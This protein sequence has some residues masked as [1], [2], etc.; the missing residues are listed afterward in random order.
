[1]A[2]N[3]DLSDGKILTISDIS[4]VQERLDNVYT[5]MELTRSALLNEL[6]KDSALEALKVIKFGKIATDPLYNGVHINYI[7]MLNQ[8]FSDIVVL[9][10]VEYLM[11]KYKGMAFDINLGALNGPDILSDDR[12]VIAECFS[13]V[14]TFNNQK[15]KTDSDKLMKEDKGK[16][17]YIFFYSHND[18][19][20]G[21][22]KDFI[23]NYSEI[24]YMRLN[25]DLTVIE[26]IEK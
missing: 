13:V 1:M 18:K 24:K 4:E 22:L 5:S 19:E 20:K 14:S 21:R 12:T 16:D 10:G 9:K 7:E 8:S 11:N 3:N 6:K 23:G 15:I 17:K 2:K 26:E 25:C